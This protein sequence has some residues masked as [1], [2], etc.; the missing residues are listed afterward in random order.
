MSYSQ[1]FFSSSL[2]LSL[3]LFVWVPCCVD[4]HRLH[5]YYHVIML[6]MFWLPNQNSDC[7]CRQLKFIYAVFWSSS[8]RVCILPF[9]KF[10]VAQSRWYQQG[11][12]IITPAS[13]SIVVV[14]DVSLLW[15]L[16]TIKFFGSIA[17][18]RNMTLV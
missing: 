14:Y 6:P 9:L 2:S 7:K 10:F 16:W 18:W 1:A 8:L 11:Y 3:S 5:L 4:I 17:H 12:A 13:I 15:H